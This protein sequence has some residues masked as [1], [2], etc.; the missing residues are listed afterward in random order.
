MLF[1]FKF[2]REQFNF[3]SYW[4]T[5][6]KKKQLK[7]RAANACKDN[8]D[9]QLRLKH[10]MI[11]NRNNLQLLTRIAGHMDYLKSHDVSL[12]LAAKETIELFYN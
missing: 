11:N 9:Y 12:Q 6:I 1:W 5:L 4:R 10:I 3:D 8:T 7:E 2:N